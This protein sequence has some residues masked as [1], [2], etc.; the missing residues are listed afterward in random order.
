VE[1][2]RRA[3]VLCTLEVGGG[4][5][6]EARAAAAGAR[7]ALDGIDDGTM[8]ADTAARNLG[9]RRMFVCKED[10]SIGGLSKLACS[11]AAAANN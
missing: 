9:T 11:R 4:V 7:R 1:R 2:Y 5:G 3:G 10:K 6:V 8:P